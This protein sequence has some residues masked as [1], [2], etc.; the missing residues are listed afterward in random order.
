M[1]IQPVIDSLSKTL[2]E[3]ASFVPRL[4]NSLLLLAIGY[5]LSL[6]VRWGLRFLLEHVGAQQLGERL[7]F[8]AFLR[9]FG[10]SPSVPRFLSNT[11]FFF[12]LLSFFTSAARLLEFVSLVDFLEAILHFV[13]RAISAA[14]LLLLGGLGA[15]FLAATVA[16]LARSVNIAYSRLLA[17]LVE[18]VLL[19]FLVII[20]I[21]LLGIDTTVLTTSFTILLA[22]LGLAIA[23]S[24]GFG[25]QE[26]ARNIIAGYYIRR[27]FSSSQELRFGRYQGRF[28]ATSGMYT[29]LE[30]SDETGQ[31]RLLSIP[32]TL[33]LRQIIL[34]GPAGP[35]PG[36]A[37]TA[38]PQV[39]EPGSSSAP[40]T[41]PSASDA[42]NESER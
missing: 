30:V 29:T 14:L 9:R 11:V 33:L 17:S 32:N 7:G 24:F 26:A 37:E 21:S 25:S 35:A 22:A 41:A 2:L 31:T 16:A 10:L 28:Q 39:G 23:L 27:H 4:I 1:N 20:A 15:R 5:V 19:A 38:G 34:G 8:A 42:D 13:P 40:G 18:Y 3:I 12:L 6:L 36:V